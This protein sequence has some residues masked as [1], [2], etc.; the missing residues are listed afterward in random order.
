MIARIHPSVSYSFTMRPRIEKNPRMFA[1]VLEAIA[2]QKGDPGAG[3]VVEVTPKVKA[4]GL[5]VSAGDDSHAHAIAEATLQHAARV[6][7]RRKGQR[8]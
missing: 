6:P 2:A 7:E 1:K 3:D 8:S 5:T 4:R